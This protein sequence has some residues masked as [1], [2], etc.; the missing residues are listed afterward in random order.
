MSINTPATNSAIV[1]A[2]SHLTL[3]FPISIFAV[4]L[5]RKWGLFSR[6]PK[7]VKNIPP[8]VT[9]KKIFTADMVTKDSPRGI[10]I[11]KYSATRC[12]SSLIWQSPTLCVV[13]LSCRSAQNRDST[14]IRSNQSSRPRI[15]AAV[16]RTTKNSN[17]NDKATQGDTMPPG[18]LWRIPGPATGGHSAGQLGAGVTEGF[19][20]VTAGGSG[21][22]QWSGG[23]GVCA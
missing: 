5:R 9:P 2:P 19:G 23:W 16:A 17:P 22:G 11:G 1:A 18:Y 6:E 21:D 10:I 14:L 8:K 13:Y 20:A 4:V 3:S 7:K 15:R 12:S